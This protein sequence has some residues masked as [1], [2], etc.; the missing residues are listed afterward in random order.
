MYSQARIDGE[1]QD[2][3]Y[4]LKLDRYK[5]HDIEVVIDRWIIGENATESR[6]AKS[7]TALQM[8]EGVV[9]VQKF[10]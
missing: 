10:A 3:E 4:D 1:L 5:T 6:M 7:K 2:I 8:G 9:M